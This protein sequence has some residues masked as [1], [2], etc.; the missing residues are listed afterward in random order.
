MTN[1]YSPAVI[2]FRGLLL[3][4]ALEF[5]ARGAALHLAPGP[6]RSGK[7]YVDCRF[8]GR[9]EGCFLDTGSAMTL[10]TP[11]FSQ[12]PSLGS[13]RFKSA[14]GRVANAEVVR[15]H[16]IQID[17]ERWNDVRIGRLPKRAESVESSVGMDLL[18]RAP[19]ALDF[20]DRA[21]LRFHPSKPR[22]TYHTLLMAEHNLLVIPLQCGPTVTQ[23]L[24][25][26]GA[27]V[28][29][30]D[31]AFIR[32]HPE[33]FHSLGRQMSGVDGTG[34]KMFVQLFRANALKIGERTFRNVMVVATDLSMLREGQARDVQLVLGFNVIRRTDWYF[35]PAAHTWGVR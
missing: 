10:L 14:S 17:R 15:V 3:L 18:G 30:A 16:S 21:E 29:A 8:D 5:C 13:F 31:T 9:I 12:Y 19:F 11:E 35:D 25:D 27:T 7:A 26:T 34:Q 23:A 24:F 4:V 22:N 2:I 1:R 32:A 33:T 6:F 20:R 28:T